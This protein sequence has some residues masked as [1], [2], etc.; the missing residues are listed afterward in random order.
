[1]KKVRGCQDVLVTKGGR[2]DE[3]VLGWLTN[4]AIAKQVDV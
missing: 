1:M 4:A 3:G 2:A